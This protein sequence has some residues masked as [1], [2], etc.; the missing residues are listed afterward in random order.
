MSARALSNI[1]DTIML[2]GSGGVRPGLA[3][4]EVGDLLQPPLRQPELAAHGIIVRNCRCHARWGGVGVIGA[5]RVLVFLEEDG[6][7]AVDG[8]RGRGHLAGARVLAGRHV[9]VG[10]GG[11]SARHGTT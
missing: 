3:V 5:C 8:V 11:N 2:R 4:E 1:S 10:G 6:V 7:G 9:G